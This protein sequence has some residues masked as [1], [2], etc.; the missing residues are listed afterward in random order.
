MKETQI[1]F[2]KILQ[3]CRYSVMTERKTR[4]VSQEDTNLK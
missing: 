3:F 4:E 1:L 2:C